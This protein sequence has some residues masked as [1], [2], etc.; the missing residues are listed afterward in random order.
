MIGMAVLG[1][2]LVSALSALAAP[3]PRGEAT[4]KKSG[5][6]VSAELL[7][8]AEVLSLEVIDAP[9]GSAWPLET[10]AHIRVFSVAK[11]QPPMTAE[12]R[13]PG[14]RRGEVAVDVRILSATHK[15]LRSLVAAGQFR[16]DLYYRIDVIELRVPP[17]RERGADVMLLADHILARLAADLGRPAPELTP[18]A[19]ARHACRSRTTR[20]SPARP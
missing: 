17:L 15:E 4:L 14:G 6:R 16:E 5:A 13:L 12:V 11:G 9:A 3:G 8:D 1:S 2:L 10:R 7:V 20:R 18:A 19:R